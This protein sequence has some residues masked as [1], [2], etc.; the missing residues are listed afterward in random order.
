MARSQTR[1]CGNARHQ[2]RLDGSDEESSPG[3]RGELWRE[4]SARGKVKGKGLSR[5]RSAVRGCVRRARGRERGGGGGD[6][7]RARRP[8]FKK[9]LDS[10]CARDES[11]VLTVSSRFK[12]L[13]RSRCD[14][15]EE[16]FLV[17]AY[18][19]RTHLRPD[20]RSS[21][22]RRVGGRTANKVDVVCDGGDMENRSSGQPPNR[23]PGAPLLHRPP[24][25]QS[26]FFCVV[27]S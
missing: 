20:K 8:D 22:R 21:W 17:A 12:R 1:G 7:Q 4:L 25:R 18:A 11:A 19:R 23:G 26:L 27:N 24:A 15:D 9:A 16:R 2:S 6:E 13:C 3:V 10:R 5:C 14:P